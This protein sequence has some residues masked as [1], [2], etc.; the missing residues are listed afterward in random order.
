M[1]RNKIF[2]NLILTKESGLNLKKYVLYVSVSEIHSK[3]GLYI[4]VHTLMYNIQSLSLY[5]YKNQKY[6]CV[7]LFV[8][9]FWSDTVHNLV[10]SNLGCDLRKLKKKSEFTLLRIAFIIKGWAL[11]KMD[12]CQN[13][14]PDKKVSLTKKYLKMF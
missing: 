9:N 13:E 1:Q 7:V 6:K 10:C 14:L 3:V 2:I 12:P 5:L 4:L 8:R 11:S